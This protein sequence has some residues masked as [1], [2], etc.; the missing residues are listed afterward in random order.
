MLQRIGNGH[1]TLP[2]AVVHF[3]EADGAVRDADAGVVDHAANDESQKLCDEK[4]GSVVGEGRR[5]VV[6]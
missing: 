4:E 6:P 1:F 5:T 3:V 2:V